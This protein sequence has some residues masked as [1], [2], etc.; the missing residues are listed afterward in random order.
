MKILGLDIEGAYG[1]MS[2]HE[3]GFYT[4]CV[5][6]VG[7]E[8]GV[9]VSDK[10]IWI[11]HN[12]MDRT[13]NGILEVQQAVDDCDLIVGQNLKY[14][15]KALTHYGIDFNHVKVWDTM[16]AEYVLSGQ[17]SRERKFGLNALAEWYKEEGK[18]DAGA[19]VKSYWDD[20]VDTCDIPVDILTKYQ[21][22]DCIVPINIYRKQLA[23][24]EQEGM[25]KSIEL[26]MEWML[27]LC[28]M[29]FNGIK[30]NM[31]KA[32]EIVEEYKGKADKI[33][34]YFRQYFDNEHLNL[35]SGDQKSAVIYGGL[36][37][38][39]HREWYIRTLKSKP[40]S[41]LRRMGTTSVT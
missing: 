12:Q 41:L 19:A 28:E 23:L 21:V 39:K 26:Q 11:E 9:I 35:G 34:D 5:G 17:D 32:Y 27:C 25:V 8:D 3:D 14:D 20:G 29:E 1:I 13:I 40:E 37:K 6:L 2:P 33:Q 24:A 38:T 30:F 16:L 4:S 36:L 7:D 18:G 10:V 22:N 31:E 15:I